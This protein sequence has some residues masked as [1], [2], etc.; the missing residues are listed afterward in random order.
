M[1]MGSPPKP[2]SRYR[3]SIYNVGDYLYA[4]TQRSSV[5]DGREKS[6]HHSRKGDA[7]MRTQK[8]HGN[9]NIYPTPPSDDQITDNLHFDF[10]SIPAHVLDGLAEAT[11]EMVKCLMKDPELRRKLEERTRNRKMREASQTLT[12]VSPSVSP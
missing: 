10:D 5:D 2:D 9:R 11:M 12:G 7:D 8:T 1:A 3:V 6:H 4:S